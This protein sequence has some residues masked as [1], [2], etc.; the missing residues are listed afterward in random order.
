MQALALEVREAIHSVS[1]GLRVGI[2]FACLVAAPALCTQPGAA[3]QASCMLPSW[4]SKQI[5]PSPAWLRL[6]SCLFLSSQEAFMPL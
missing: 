5:R 4:C 2:V 6:D 3:R 1:V